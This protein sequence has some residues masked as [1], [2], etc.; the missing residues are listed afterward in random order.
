MLRRFNTFI[1]LLLLALLGRLVHD[2]VH[3]AWNWFILYW[4]AIFGGYFLFRG[5]GL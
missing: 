2:G 1:G 4:D 3:S 5:A